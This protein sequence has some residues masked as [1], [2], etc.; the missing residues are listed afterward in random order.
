MKAIIQEVK[1]SKEW[2]SKYGP[3]FTFHVKYDDQVAVY[4]S[5]TKEQKKFISG[6]EAEFTEETKTYKDKQTGVEKPYTVIKP[7]MQERQS[8]FGKALSKEKSRYSGFAVSY[9]K[10]LLVAGR[11]NKEE[12]AD[13]AWILFE[14]MVAMDKTLES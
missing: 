12:L 1:F 8:N 4:N 9:A 3:M 2:V 7:V 10:D 11:I 14:L 5:K 13:Q 6:Q